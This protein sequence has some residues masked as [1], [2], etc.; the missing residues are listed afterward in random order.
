MEQRSSSI[1]N[2]TRDTAGRRP[3]LA[4]VGVSALFPGSVDVRGFWH[5]I[6]LGRDLIGDVPPHYW[7]P[8]DYHDPD[9]AAPDKTYGRRGA[10]LSPVD[11]DPIEFGIPPASLPSTDT[12]QLLALMVAKRVLE[13][14][15]QGALGGSRVD[16]ERISV[17]LGAAAG[18]ELLGEMASRLQRPVWLK[19]LREQGVPEDEAQ[20]ICQRIADQY[21][22]WTEATFPGLLGNVIT[23]R[24]ANRFDLGGTNCTTDAACASS[25]SALSMAAN[26]LY[27]GDSDMVLTGGVDTTNDPFLFMCFSKTPALSFS[28]DCRPFSEDA[29]GTMLGEGLGMVAL[30]RLA[31]A[32]RDGDRIYAVLRGVGSSSD[33]RAKSV[34]APRAQGQAR[35]LRRAYELAGYSPSTVELLEA[36]GT[37]T[38]AG[39]I[40]EFRGLSQ[41][42]DDTGRED[43]QWCALGSVKSQVG[44]TKGSAGVAGLIKVVMALHHKVLPPTIKVARPDPEM[45]IEASPF[46]LNTRSRPWIRATDHPRR[47]SVSSFGFGG[48]NFH[49]ALEEYAGEAPRAWRLRTVPSELVLLEAGDGAALASACRQTAG[50]LEQR[51]PGLL[52]HLARSSQQAHSEGGGGRDRAR[53]AL[54]AR[55]Q[56]QLREHLLQAAERVDG[57]PDEAF[58]LPA[59]LHYGPAGGGEAGELAFVFPGQGSQYLGMGAELAMTH[60]PAREVWDLAASIPLDGRLRLH[61]VVFPRPVFSDAGREQLAARLTRTEWAQPAL[62]AASLATLS[63]LRQ[64]GL[65]PRHVGGHSFG[66]I[67][68]LC[69]A[70]VL[71]IGGMLRVARRRGELMA[72]ASSSAPGA[73]LAVVCEPSRLRPLLDQWEL[74]LVIANH[75]S[76]RQVALSGPEEAIEEARKQL[77]KE[78]IVTRRLPVATAFHSPLVSDSAEPFGQFLQGIPFGPAACPVYANSE[79]APYPE[80]PEQMR[81]LLAGQIARPVRFVEQIEAMYAAGARIFVEVGPGSVLTGLVQQCLEGR[82][83]LALSTDRKGGHGVTALQNALGALAASGVALDLAQL[84]RPFRESRDPRTQQQPR[85]VIPIDGA[86]VGKLYPPEGGAAALPPPNPPRETPAEHGP[87]RDAHN[88]EA[89]MSDKEPR[90]AGPAEANGTQPAQAPHEGEQLAWIQA[91]KDLQRQTAEAHAAYQQTMAQSHMAFLRAAESTARG[92]QALVAGQPLASGEVPATSQ[93][94]PAEVLPAEVPATSQAPPAEVPATSQAPDMPATSQVLPLAKVPG[95]WQAPDMPATSQVLPL[96]K[97]PGTSQ[98]PGVPLAEV[99]GTSQDT[100]QVPDIQAT[101]QVPG[102]QQVPE[103]PPTIETPPAI[104]PREV[105]FRQLLLSVVADKTGYPQEILELEMNLESDL[106]IDSIKRVEILSAIQEQAPWLPE[107]DASVMPQLKTLGQVLVLL[108]EYGRLPE[109]EPEPVAEAE[110][111]PEAEAE[112]EPEAEA[113]PEPEAEV[114]AD[115][116]TAAE[117][118]AEAEAEAGAEAGAEAAPEAGPEPDLDSEASGKEKPKEDKEEQTELE[119]KLEADEE[120]AADGELS[121]ASAREDHAAQEIGRF[122]VQEVLAPASG[123]SMLTRIRGG[124][125]AITDDGVG[126]GRVL[127]AKLRQLGF[128]ATLVSRE[129]PEDAA[130]MIFL[131]GLREIADVDQAIGVNREAFLAA[132]RVANRFVNEGGLLVTVQDTGGDFGLSGKSEK[133]AWQGGLAALA[134]TAAREW[135]RALVKA[136]DLERGGRPS[137]ELAE[138]LFQEL[139]SGGKELEVGLHADGTRTTLE[140]RPAELTPG[141]PKLSGRSVVV[142]SGGARGV[143]AD[144]VV[145]LARRYSPR[146][147]LLGRTPIQDDPACC[148]GIADDAGLKRALLEEARSQ[149]RTVTPAQLGEQARLVQANREIRRTL[150]ALREAGSSAV[151]LSLDVRDAEAVKQAIARTREKW[152]PITGIIHGAGVLADKSIADKSPEQFEQ[153]FDTKVRALQVLLEATTDDPLQVLCL[154][155]SVAARHGNVGQCDYAM[156]NEVLNHVAAA[157]ARRRGGACLVRSIN[158]G[159]WEGGMVSPSLALRFRQMGVPLIP[160]A[161]GARM[162]VE[163]LQ[164]D[165]AGP[166]GP[167]IGGLAPN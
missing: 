132:R 89:T 37:G 44:H 41:V 9:P 145:A 26:E 123:W 88:E 150:E 18:M 162:L 12:C 79:A 83:H 23:G 167:L 137:G 94:L 136:V 126:V 149:G 140:D 3:P 109:A 68:A 76:P 35:A 99:P 29:D 164:G 122:A 13:D 14:A 53:L 55:D 48:T 11:F 16:P 72:G 114:E 25:F 27:L 158:W 85:L 101:S 54:V 127:T 57:D 60:E 49:V 153:V 15:A 51:R 81:H 46:Y 69:A 139:T 7:L 165:A 38:M 19:A 131:G 103:P 10:F 156:A 142:V 80:D 129:V 160:L 102:G 146:F 21:V 77:R 91:F 5:D 120:P 117:A 163:E 135:D 33:G 63:V 2:H 157:E 73:M 128:S 110:P 71:D 64:V 45:E 115:T 116:E 42:F 40:T 66:E 90:Q 30:R 144:T 138:A 39:D 84:W 100:S 22:P 95:T 141:E 70:G 148:Q 67:T 52:A 113:E 47:A 32:E 17:I 34:Y 161:V 111:E 97:V 166:V 155:S 86:N 106:G 108:E 118:E 151:Y 59:G 121:E 82:P 143:T 87:Q 50:E 154:F 8:E 159:P 133:Q 147:L 56:A 24:I 36:H 75:N 105:D 125:L 124:L 78:K 152:G 31:D 61:E 98:T 92:L 107:V 130:G 65:E 43:R 58:S 93:A 1:G 104:D 112:P 4:V 62:G 20:A 96:A 134:R 119:V 6:L 28:G 74:P